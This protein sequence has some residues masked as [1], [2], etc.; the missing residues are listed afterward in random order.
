MRKKDLRGC[1]KKVIATALVFCMALPVGISY[2]RTSVAAQVID[3]N[4][5]KQMLWSTS[6]ESAD[7]FKTSTLDSKGANNVA[8]DG[9]STQINGSL[10]GMIGST[11]GS[12]AY[13]TNEVIGNLFD[14]NAETK[15][16][17]SVGSPEVI[18]K[19]RNDEKKVVKNYFLTSAN[20]VSGRDPKNWVLQGRNSDNEN[21][22]RIDSRSNQVFAGRFRQKRYALDNTT[23]YSQ[24]RLQITANKS[25][26]K[27][28]QLAEFTL[29]TED[30][31][32]SGNYNGM[33]SEITT[34]PSDAWTQKS[35]A[36]WTGSSSLV[37][38]GSHSGTGRAYSYNVIY[39][40]LNITVNH[41][42]NLRYVIFPSMSNG[43]FYDYEYTQMHMAVDLKFKDGTYLSDLNAVDQN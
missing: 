7:N 20:D 33:K 8:A 1:M 35:N 24:Y 4:Y 43:D 38:S 25:G 9:V 16:L 2:Q 19:L 12:D 41:N 18:I 5:S 17:T 29:S 22:T 3:A 32:Q 34:G 37:C 6:F 10:N 28:T 23:A 42:T 13:N 14:N 39:D 15:Y 30:I 21:W 40:N 26:G 27:L 36:G 31:S 11:S